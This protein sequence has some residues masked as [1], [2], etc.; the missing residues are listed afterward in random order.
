VA[1]C[2]T[3]QIYFPSKV[4][5]DR[6]EYID[7]YKDLAIKEMKRSGVP[8][9]ITLA[10]GL[11]ESN[12]GSSTLARK[13][14]NHFGIKCHDWT[15]EIIYHN[16]DINDECFRKYKSVYQS[17]IDHSNFLKNSERYAFLFDLKQKDYQGWARGLKEA[18]YATNRKYAN[19]LIKIIKDNQLYR[20]DK[21]SRKKDL[22]KDKN[23]EE[24]KKLNESN[25]SN[26][27]EGINNLKDTGSFYINLNKRKKY[28]RNGI[29][30]IIVKKGDEL[31]ELAKELEMMPWE[32]FRYNDLPRD[33]V[34]FEGQELY[35]QPKRNKAERGFEYHIAEEGEIMYNISQKYGIKLKKLYQKNLM[36]E[37]EEPEVSQKIWLR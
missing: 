14:N 32:I 3:T 20:Y 25:E 31:L 4:S 2:K 13:A 34:F 11:L 10:Q 18:G 15:G 8:A 19:M 35:I 33:A 23:V 6:E 16:D 21:K 27:T 5:K 36:E 1:S 22:K 30:Y 29:E 7:Q 24:Q 9:S 12:N 17:Y 37:G 26:E 28:Q